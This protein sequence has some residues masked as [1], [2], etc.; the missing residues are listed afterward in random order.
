MAIYALGILPLLST[1][2]AKTN[3]EKQPLLQ[4]A[5]ADDITG[6][7]NLNS[8]RLWCDQIVEYG[9]TIGYYVNAEKT[10]LIVKPHSEQ[11]RD[12]FKQQETCSRTL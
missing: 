7:G 2:K 8:L 11:T 3:L 1:I 9:P 5:F 12:M 4:V 6:S 10:C